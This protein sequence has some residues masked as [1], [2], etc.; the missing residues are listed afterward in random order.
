MRFALFGSTE[1][2]AAFLCRILGLL[3]GV[4]LRFAEQTAASPNAAEQYTHS[5]YAVIYKRHLEL[6][7][8]DLK[9]HRKNSFLKF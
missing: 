2:S 1:P 4:L 5:I 3:Y 7:Q 6:Q 9:N 8:I